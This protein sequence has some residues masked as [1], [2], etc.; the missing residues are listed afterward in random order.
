MR[1]LIGRELSAR[2]L[3][4]A[5]DCGKAT[6]RVM[7]ATGEQ[8]VIVEPVSLPTLREGAEELQRLILAA[9][10]EDRPVIAVE[11]TGSL[12]HPWGNLSR[13]DPFAPRGWPGSRGPAGHAAG[14]KHRSPMTLNDAS[15]ESGVSPADAE[16]PL[17]ERNP[18][19][20][21]EEEPKAPTGIEPV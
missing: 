1:H 14:H 16:T 15:C 5:I 3:V 20:Q 18:G 19:C 8:G 7:L 4:V 17:L 9:G 12:H 10:S 13:W 21:A 6:N 2:T 11:A